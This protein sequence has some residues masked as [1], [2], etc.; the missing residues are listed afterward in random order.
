M[1]LAAA[2]ETRQP[3]PTDVPVPAVDAAPHEQ[4]VPWRHRHLL[5]VDV[6]SADDLELVMRTADA[7]REVL[8]RPIPRV[9]ALRAG[10]RPRGAGAV[11]SS[12]C[13]RAL[14]GVDRA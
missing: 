14:R 7:M 5:D 1:N 10:G 2:D 8:G 9:P 3:S 11:L 12:S 4:D 6:L 13:S